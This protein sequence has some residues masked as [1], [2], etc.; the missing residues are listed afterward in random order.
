[1]RLNRILLLS[2]FLLAIFTLGAVSAEDNSTAGDGINVTFKEK[3]YEKDLGTVD[4]DVPENTSGNLKVK[5]NNF[6]IYNENITGSVK[7]PIRIPKE[8]PILV[9]NKNT[10]HYTYRI[11]VFFNDVQLKSNHT[12]KVMKVAP[13]YEIQGFRNEI[14]QN[15]DSEHL[16]LFFP[17][18][19]YGMIE[20]YVDGE[21]LL[22]RTAKQYT[23]LNITDFNRL[24]MGVHTVRIKYGGDDYYLPF[25]KTFS[26]DV[27]DMRIHIPTKMVLDHDDCITAK[28]INNTDGKVFV[29]V[30]DV[31][32][33]KSKL[34][35]YG[36][37]LH[38]MFKEITCGEHL[39]EVQY[40]ASNFTKSKKAL[41]NVSYVVYMDTFN[42]VYGMENTVYFYLPDDMDE[43]L[44]NVTIDGVRYPLKIENSY[45]DLDI[46]KLDAGNHTIVFDYPGDSKYSAMRLED[47]FT[48][49]Y[50]IRVDD[51]LYFF[52]NCRVLLSLP[53]QVRGNLEVYV[54]SKLYKSAPLV[55]GSAEIKIMGLVPGE[56]NVVAKYSGN[57]FMVNSR[58][59]TVSLRPSLDYPY[60][61]RCGD[62]ESIDVIASKDAKGYVLFNVSGKIYNVTVKNGK[63]SLPLKNF[64]A[65]VYDGIDVKY[66][67][68]NGF[69]ASWWCYVEILPAEI[70]LT[71]VKTSADGAKLSVYVNGKL[72]KN[73]YLTFKVDK[74]TIKAKTDSK[75]VANIKLASGK[76]T[77]T[78][79]FK[80]STASKRVTVYGVALKSVNVKKS[81]KKLVLSATV[82][83]GKNPIRYKY[84]VFKFNNKIYVAKTNSK[85]IAK[86]DIKKSVLKSLKVGKKV[87][88]E[89]SYFT[90]NVKKTA[91]VKK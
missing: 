46:S 29:F 68:E 53:S 72:A 7:V 3:V 19:A 88:Y 70:K 63:A 87:T 30:D 50:E 21:F 33:Y 81:A 2:I 89:V 42:Y 47:N 36:E 90:A 35:E 12:L 26:F 37:F 1:M 60:E 34:D 22:N 71:N 76:H 51:Y 38:S 55:N 75:G 49:S 66:V 54:D 62:D 84:V 39:I 15:D 61:M 82:K 85:G 77:I 14:L 83:L 91:V 86:V 45:A 48:V 56:Y 32:V 78:A 20:I 65:G 25:D 69:D 79:N 31:L 23:F 6:E 9:V 44:I 80:N 10:D 4:V 24:N 40:N 59:V 74:K 67:G 8:L 17:E 28:I 11:H 64:E 18:S 13:N 57:D 27:V 52:D 41:V 43:K 5:I 16:A 58:N 73:T